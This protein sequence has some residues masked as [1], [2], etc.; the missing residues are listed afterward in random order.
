MTARSVPD[1]VLH[2]CAALA[3]RDDTALASA[4]LAR[5]PVHAGRTHEEL[6]RWARVAVDAGRDAASRD[7]A[8]GDT[9]PDEQARQAGLTVRHA[10]DG[11]RSGWVVVAEYAER[12]RE[13]RV[14]QDALQLAE[15]LVDRLGWRGWYPTGA[16]RRAAVAH[17][18]G[19]RRLHGP[20]ARELRAALGLV[21]LR[22]GRH[23][24]YGHVSGTP[25]LFA[26]GYAERTC[27]LGRSPLLLTQALALAAR[28]DTRKDGSR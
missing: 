7:G 11:L 18:L 23:R 28:V 6:D 16:L 10:Q 20:P 13:V 9:D 25:E 15:W 22:L 2:S 24:R 17:E 3:E 14:H 27:S 19:H 21:T 4:L 5:Q 8:P 26:H 1:R 12:S